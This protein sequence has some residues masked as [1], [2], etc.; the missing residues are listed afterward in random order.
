M[1]Q[2]AQTNAHLQTQ[3]RVSNEGAVVTMARKRYKAMRINGQWYCGDYLISG[4]GANMFKCESYEDAWKGMIRLLES[5]TP[6]SPVSSFE[7]EYIMPIPDE[8]V[9]I[10]AEDIASAVAHFHRTYGEDVVIQK[11]KMNGKEISDGVIRIVQRDYFMA[12]DND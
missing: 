4:Q 7:F 2:A 6:A 1:N 8:Y 11:L 5:D 12:L 10:S 9:T 3:F